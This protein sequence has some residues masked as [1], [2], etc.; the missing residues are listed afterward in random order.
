LLS[1]DN[2]RTTLPPNFLD[3]YEQKLGN[4]QLAPSLLYRAGN[5]EAYIANLH[6]VLETRI[7]YAL[8]LA[9]DHQTDFLM[10]HFLI[11]DIAQ[12]TLWKHLDSSHPWHNPK[13]A[14][15][16][17]ETI[18]RLYARIDSAL[19]ELLDILPKDLTVLLM[20]DHGFGPLYRTINLNNFFIQTG[21]MKVKQNAGTKVRHFGFKHRITPAL[22]GAVIRRLGL[23]QAKKRFLPTINLSNKIIGFKDV[24][25]GRTIAYSIGH[26]G[27]VYVNLKGREP[28]GIV[29]PE[30]YISARQQIINT[31]KTLKDPVTNK[32]IVSEIIPR[33][34]AAQG[35]YLDNGPDLH[36]IMDGYCSMAY[37]M[38]AADGEIFTEQKRYNSGDHRREG[39]FIAHGPSFRRGASIEGASILD[40]TPTILHLMGV[41]VPNDM[42]GRVLERALTSEFCAQY[43]ITFQEPGIPNKDFRQLSPAEESK[44]EERL[45]GL[46]YLG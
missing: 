1:P 18:L 34:Q 6:D 2:G 29:E 19:A 46:G 38:F 21:L 10:V 44:V 41:P 42:D 4:Y 33:E 45:R 20:S 13:L 39:I 24:D 16:Y 3:A 22:A 5:E 9:S 43:P 15:R 40:L 23:E 36:L 14:T 26:L 25:W 31:L 17:G 8:H 35:P 7:R 12:H 11:T 32:P 28:H 30:N 27:Q 37:P